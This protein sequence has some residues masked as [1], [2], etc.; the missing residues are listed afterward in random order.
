M[1]SPKGLPKVGVVTSLPNGSFASIFKLESVAAA[2]LDPILFQL[3]AGARKTYKLKIFQG[4]GI[5][6]PDPPKS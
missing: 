4:G 5:C 2:E 3:Y 1:S 6:P